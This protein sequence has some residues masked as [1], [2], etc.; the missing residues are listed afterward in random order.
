[1]SDDNKVL[2][3]AKERYKY[4]VERSEHNRKR[5]KEDIRFAAASPDDPWQWDTL[6]L[7]DRKTKQRPA[8][9]I[10]KM[11]LHIRQV[12]NDIRQNRPQVRYRPADDKADPE[13]A[14]ILNGVVR[15]IEAHSQ[16][17]MAYDS[18]VLNQVTHGEG[19]IRVLADYIDEKS[20]DQD[21]FIRRIDDPFSVK[22]DP[23]RLDWVGSDAK[24]GFI[25]DLVHEDEFKK[26]YP[27]A[28]PIDW[29]FCKD[30]LWFTDNKHVLIAEYFELV[31]EDAKLY[32]FA[33]GATMLEGEKTPEGVFAGERPIK[34]RKSTRKKVVWRKITGA[35]V[36]EEKEFPSKYIPIVCAVGNQWYVDGKKYISGIVRNSKDSQ[37]M[38]NVAQ[39]AIVERVLLAPKSPFIASMEA[40]NGFEDIWKTANTEP[41]SFLPHNAFDE[42]GNPIPPPKRTEA[43]TV[44]PG[45]QQIAQGA[46]DDIKSETGQFDASLGQRSNETS[47]K[48][49]IA[50]QREGDNATFHYVDNFA[51]TIRQLG[52]I[53]L[54]MMPRVLDTRRVAKILG[55]DGDM[56]TAW[57]DP[58]QPQALVEVRDEQN[59]IARIFN[60]YV[61]VYDVYASVGPSYATRRIEASEG[62]NMA[63]QASPELWRVIGD[64]FI[65]AQ[66]WPGAEE[67]A[68]RMKTILL[69]QV[70]QMVGQ[71]EGEQQIPPQVQQAIEAMGQ[72]LQA[73]KQAAGQMEQQ[74]QQTAGK[75]LS[76]QKQLLS[77]EAARQAA[78]I[79]RD[80]AEALLEIEQRK[81]AAIVEVQSMQQPDHDEASEPAAPAQPMVLPDVN[82]AIASVL[83]PIAQAVQMQAEGTVAAM[84]Q[85][86][87]GSKQTNDLLAAIL[88][89]PREP[90]V[91][92][93]SRTPDGLQGT[94]VPVEKE[95]A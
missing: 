72:E 29:D 88:H 64:Q 21:I 13:V 11:P 82:G 12:A 81:Q 59:K 93:V 3:T 91:L 55:E 37:R 16:A 89:K 6:T 77:A 76:M 85:I 33:N 18:C 51:Q 48:A 39:S 20:F 32:L 19:F 5:Q 45:L 52:V 26:L 50:R 83:E 1:M 25:D 54:D 44:E 74:L 53:I 34:E 9:T 17:D 62:M 56:A 28:E 47:G 38:Y 36:L 69:P 49:I 86:A 60:P 61:G 43:A 2:E 7:Q 75:E 73:T 67:M 68:E 57:L 27:D 8:L 41:H 80:K 15:H 40:I 30:G 63:L 35:S 95:A 14:T 84:A 23:D 71:D 42:A 22:L 66:D 10:N 65:K 58:N 46:S 70:Q 24:W 87:E 94:A 31:E 4:A 78:E 92:T 90:M 79:E